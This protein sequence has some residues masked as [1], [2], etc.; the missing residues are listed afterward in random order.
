VRHT[1]TTRYALLLAFAL[2]TPIFFS[3]ITPVHGATLYFLTPVPAFTQE[4]LTI[5]LVLTV[6]GA[7]PSASYQFS[8]VVKD[9][10]GKNW[11]STLQTHNTT[12]TES[13]FSV[14]L[15][16]PSTSF[17]GRNSLVG[18]YNAQVNQVK[19]LP[20]TNVASSAFFILL[21]NLLEYQRTD[22]VNIRASGYNGTEST[23]VTIRTQTSSTLVFSRTILASPTGVLTANWKIPKNATIDNYLVTITGTSTVKTPPDLQGFAV[24]VASMSIASL[25]SAKSSYQR[26]DSMRFSFAPVYPDGTPATTGVALLTLRSPSNVNVTMTATYNATTHVFEAKYTTSITNV[27]GTWTALLAASAYG[28]GFGNTGPVAGL[29]NA[30]QLTIATLGINILVNPYFSIGQQVKFNASITYPDGTIFRSGTA[31][32]YLVYSGTPVVTNTIPILFDTT[33]NLWVGSY[34]PQSTDPG[35][36]WTLKVN[37]TDPSTPPNT[38][39]ATRIITLQDRPPVATFSVT[40]TLTQT[41]HDVDFDATGSYDPDGQ[42]VTY[43]WNFGDG[44]TGSGIRVTHIYNTVQGTQQVYTV[45]LVVTDNSGSTGSFFSTVTITDRPPVVS[46]TKSANITIVSQSILI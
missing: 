10:S 30:P 14:L 45:S 8:F 42:V 23:T 11:T 22:T 44:T 32:A 7:V 15:I 37:A 18:Q 4:G 35:G 46:F 5:T 16:Y 21:T 26:T 36:L 12:A 34:T 28:D 3:S 9:P 13:Q 33:L 6:V 19:P 1:K 17:A 41:G 20:L 24:K 2:L 25:S 40:P 27:T 38:G 43:I 31:G 39:S 29:S